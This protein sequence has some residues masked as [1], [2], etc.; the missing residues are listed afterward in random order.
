MTDTPDLA[1]PLDVYTASDCKNAVIRDLVTRAGMMRKS[2][3]SK[4]HDQQSRVALQLA[5]RVLEVIIRDYEA[6]LIVRSG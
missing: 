2:S 3:R 5:V 4:K 1:E 6:N